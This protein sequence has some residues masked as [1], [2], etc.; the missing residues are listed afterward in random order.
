M[1]LI[2]ETLDVVSFWL[3]DFWRWV[4]LHL[5]GHWLDAPQIRFHEWRPLHSSRPLFANRLLCKA[6]P[7]K[8]TVFLHPLTCVLHFQII[9]GDLKRRFNRLLSLCSRWDRSWRMRCFCSKFSISQRRF[10]MGSFRAN[11]QRNRARLFDYLRMN[12]RPAVPFALRWILIFW[13]VLWIY[14]AHSIVFNILLWDAEP[15]LLKLWFWHHLT[16]DLSTVCWLFYYLLL[17]VWIFLLLGWEIKF[18]YSDAVHLS[19]NHRL[20]LVC[21]LGH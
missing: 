12:R 17:Q 11:L 21:L 20:L 19:G 18:G 4:T 8:I 15:F 10:L 1:G 2:S 5:N 16:V 6:A 3:N 13:S 14:W 7:R 9:H